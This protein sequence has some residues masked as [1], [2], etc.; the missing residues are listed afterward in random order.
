MFGIVIF[1]D[2]F[3]TTLALFL[4]ISSTLLMFMNDL[5]LAPLV[6]KLSL[7]PLRLV[8]LAIPYRNL[9]CLQNETWS[10]NRVSFN[11]QIMIVT[12]T[13]CFSSHST[14]TLRRDS[15]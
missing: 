6:L 12:L 3:G 14:I 15:C 2:S 5:S 7:S 4:P 1:L 9:M 8:G 13:F 10:I 11:I